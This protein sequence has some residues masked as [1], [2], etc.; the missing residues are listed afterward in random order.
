MTER[1]DPHQAVTLRRESGDTSLVLGIRGIA[2]LKGSDPFN[3]TNCCITGYAIDFGEFGGQVTLMAMPYTVS[4]MPR[5]SLNAVG[6]WDEGT[7][8]SRNA[9]G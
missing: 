2:Y 1:Q 3:I 7:K 4:G 9:F 6:A 8:V 5:Q